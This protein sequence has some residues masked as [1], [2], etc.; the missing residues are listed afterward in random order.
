[1]VSTCMCEELFYENCGV[2]TRITPK[3]LQFHSCEYV[4]RRNALIP[5][6]WET[7]VI[8]QGRMRGA[9]AP[10]AYHARLEKEYSRQMD[11]MGA[12]L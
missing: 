7:A 9:E 11:L 10:F 6:A 12:G 3:Y 8:I 5:K 1:M 4:Q 2:R